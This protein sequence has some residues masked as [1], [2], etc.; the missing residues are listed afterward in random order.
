MY[1]L[2]RNLL[3]TI[4]NYPTLGTDNRLVDFEDLAAAVDGHVAEF[5]EF[6]VVV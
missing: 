2:H 4:P 3:T 6:G 1:L 5:G